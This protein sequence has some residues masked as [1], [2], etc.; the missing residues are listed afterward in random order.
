LQD[1]T[2]DACREERLTFTADN[3]Q[4]SPAGALTFNV[5][6]W[7][8]P[9]CATKLMVEFPVLPALTVRFVGLDEIVKSTT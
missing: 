5:S 2:E 4:A 6:V 7:L 9:F 1:K 3:E 8:K